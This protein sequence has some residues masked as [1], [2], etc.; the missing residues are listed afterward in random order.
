MWLRCN[1]GLKRVLWLLLLLS[2]VYVWSGRFLA[3]VIPEQRSGIE[4]WLTQRL[5]TPVS[6]GSIEVTGHLMAPNIVLHDIRVMSMDAL[7]TPL[8]MKLGWMGIDGWAS[9]WHQQLRLRFLQLKGLNVQVWQTDQDQWR[10][11]GFEALQKTLSQ[12]S[13]ASSLSSSA[14]T[15]SM[16]VASV[17]QTLLWL[18]SLIVQ[19]GLVFEDIN[20]QLVPNNFLPIQRAP[21]E[22][23]PQWL[24]LLYGDINRHMPLL[25]QN[26]W[27]QR[28]SLHKQDQHYELFSQMTLLK[29][30]PLRL[31]FSARING[32]SLAPDSWQAQAYLKLDNT[33]IKPWVGVH[34]PADV[35]LD[36]LQGQAEMWLSLQSGRLQRLHARIALDQ[37]RWRH[38]WRG[39]RLD[40]WQGA[41]DFQYD[42]RK[43]WHL[44]GYPSTWHVGHQQWNLPAWNLHRQVQDNQLISHHV[45]IAEVDMA[46]LHQLINAI[47]Q[48]DTMSP[49]PSVARLFKQ[50]QIPLLVPQTMEYWLTQLQQYAPSGMLGDIQWRRTLTE[51][52]WQLNI[53][54]V[55]LSAKNWWPGFSGLHA[56]VQGK[57]SANQHSQINIEF[58][59][60][61]LIFDW[62]RVFRQALPATRLQG[63][64]TLTIKPQQWQ[65]Q[66]QN[67]EALN[68]DAIASGHAVLTQFA[69]EAPLLKLQAQMRHVNAQA[70]AVYLP[71]KVMAPSLVNW[72]EMA[73]L[74][75]DIQQGDFLY[76]G[77]LQK[78]K[79]RYANNLLMRYQ[80]AN[81]TIDYLPPW[82][83]LEQA[84]GQVDVV[85]KKVQVSLQQAKVLGA[86]VLPSQLTIDEIDQKLR[87][88][89]QADAKGDVQTGLAVLAKSPLQPKLA[90]LLAAVSGQGPINLRL[91]LDAPL[92]SAATDA[93]SRP[94]WANVRTQFDNATIELPLLKLT[95]HKFNGELI[96]DTVKGV[97]IPNWRASLFD[98]TLQGRTNTQALSKKT[99][100]IVTEFSGTM[101]LKPFN[102]WLQQPLV[103]YTSGTAA[104][105]AKL[106]LT[107]W[108]KM[109]GAFL[110]VDSDLSGVKVSFPPPFGLD[111]KQTLNL[112]YR[113]QLDPQRPMIDVRYGPWL[114]L[115]K[116][117]EALGIYF[118]DVH[119]ELRGSNL[120]AGITVVG[121]LPDVDLQ[122]W[123]QV[124]PE[125][126]KSNVSAAASAVQA[127][128]VWSDHVLS[129][130][131]LDIYLNELRW[132]DKTLG[133]THLKLTPRQQDWLL[134]IH[135]TNTDLEAEVPIAFVRH[136]ANEGFTSLTRINANQQ[137]SMRIARL[138]LPLSASS[139]VIRPLSLLSPVQTSVP[140]PVSLAPQFAP[141]VFPAMQLSI[142]QLIKQEKNIGSVQTRIQPATTG[143]MFENLQANIK[144]VNL[145]GHAQWRWLP[146]N[147]VNNSVHLSQTS[148]FVGQLTTD[149]MLALLDAWQYPPIID[150]KTAQLNVDVSWPGNPTDFAIARLQ[151]KLDVKMNNGRLLKVDN[152]TAS[153][154]VAG[155][156]NFETIIRRM[157]LDFSDLFKK[158]L[159]FDEIKGDFVLTNTQMHTDNFVLKGPAATFSVSGD[160]DLLRQQLNHRLIVTLPV[161]R[162]L[163]LPAAATGGL[164]AAAT[165]FLIEQAIGDRLDK[166]TELTFTMQ[167]S[168][169]DPK[170]EKR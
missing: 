144:K 140:P 33:D 135:S 143:L 134:S 167:G 97:S 151:G 126:K 60:P 89:L 6:I 73:V 58:D 37:A 102:E 71:T 96:Y 166:L 101:P 57:R 158:G 165:A 9:L 159:A 44:Q 148:Q 83:R 24:K 133:S 149:N 128:V 155:I 34:L 12:T 121:Q 82:P 131:K 26:L 150:A 54:N 28:M 124:L 107:P 11:G 15:R 1:R 63:Q 61:K 116:Q 49:V 43:Q 41:F 120:P 86:S 53:S 65:L 17:H 111:G 146:F 38:Q 62:P 123:L 127:A 66:V 13:T 18:D 74:A 91:Q 88:K 72:L 132:Q 110:Q 47:A 64:A 106:V 77:R 92:G 14:N 39:Y 80:F 32:Q 42:H 76:Q 161:S 119:P 85:G 122:R 81:A 104:F 79:A 4:Y 93:Q 27:M 10:V 31:T 109:Q 130:R 136:W 108:Q 56:Q 75:G 157:Q 103:A 8:T 100:A 23:A 152:T 68:T 138:R 48:F 153:V 164:P 163:V 78:E 168:W 21:G 160:A 137:I 5:A 50:H 94:L 87:L 125:H 40:H 145:Q 46:E 129:L 2:V 55:A 20:L 162:N 29:N 112:R 25:P 22:P 118:G 114:R 16:R 69:N 67:W 170:I 19:R 154:R 90:G 45:Q 70:A 105:D 7:H 3:K 141:D 59:S 36:A 84:Q 169:Q 117:P 98:Q 95:A 35:T 147:A 99:R 139:E 30:N 52:S 156:M 115:L 113:Q 142:A 51:Q